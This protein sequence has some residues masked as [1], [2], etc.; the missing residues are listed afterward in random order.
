[1]RIRDRLLAGE[2]HGC[3]TWGEAAIKLGC[4]ERRLRVVKAT[5]VSEGHHVELVPNLGSAIPDLGSDTLTGAKWPGV[6]AFDAT[7]EDEQAAEN[8]EAHALAP[9]GYHVKG[10]STL[11]DGDGLV[12]QR[13]VKT[14]KEADDA[15]ASLL[16]A[17]ERLADSWPSIADPVPAPNHEVDDLLVVLPMGDPHIGMLAWEQECGENFDLEIAERNLVAAVD[18]LIALAP[19]ARRCL[20]LTVGDTFHSDGLSNST[21]KGTRVDVDG[22]TAKMLQVGIR[23]FRRAIDKSLAVF[24]DVDVKIGRGNH[25]HLL[26]LVLSIALQQYYENEPRVH[27]DPSPEEFHWYRFGA[28]LLGVTHGDKA[29]SM[30]LMGTMAVD[31]AKD[32]G[33]T[34]HRRIYAGHLHHEI[35]KEVH[36]VT[37]DHLNTLAGQDDWHRRMGYRSTRH[38]RMDVF[39]REDGFINRHIVGVEAL[40]RAA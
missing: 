17:C 23:T 8:R 14:N 13:W 9:D 16:K 11:Y 40:R 37:I 1:M 19:K 36:G 25:D 30:E 28:N 4:H 6:A 21:T 12:K 24:D 18:H 10:V 31:R 5:L 15:I 27:I 35:T 3:A 7:P 26:A 29:K 38:M 33:E 22:R 32:W 39:H 2:H 34:R 20:L